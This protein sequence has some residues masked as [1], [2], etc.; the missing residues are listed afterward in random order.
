[1]RKGDVIFIILIVLLTI[2][3]VTYFHKSSRV[4]WLEGQ[5]IA[6]A[7]AT[8]I[9]YYTIGFRDDGTVVWDKD[10]RITT[11]RNVE[12]QPAKKKGRKR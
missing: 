10:K 12:R 11:F 2:I 6:I 1:M 8:T 9:T 5:R 3:I 4:E 7:D